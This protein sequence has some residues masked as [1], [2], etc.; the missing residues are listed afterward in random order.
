MK[1]VMVMI[2]HSIQCRRL[3]ACTPYVVFEAVDF[4]ESELD[5]NGVS[6]IDVK[7][8]VMDRF[9]FVLMRFDLRVDNVVLRRIETR[10]FHKFGDDHVLREFTWKEATFVFILYAV[11]SALRSSQPVFDTV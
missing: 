8:R 2:C 9:W 7:C 6:K 3:S 5:D 4:W 1:I 11:V 10:L